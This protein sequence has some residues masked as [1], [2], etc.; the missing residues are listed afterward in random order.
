MQC[1]IAGPALV[2]DRLH[3][4]LVA[5]VL[6]RAPFARSGEQRAPDS[7][8]LARASGENGGVHVQPRAGDAPDE[9]AIGQT[10]ER[11]LQMIDEPPSQPV[12][13]A[14][15][16]G[17]TGTQIQ[18]DGEW[19]MGFEIEAGA[20][21]EPNDFF[22]LKRTPTSRFAKRAGA[23]YSYGGYRV[24]TRPLLASHGAHHLVTAPLTRR[25]TPPPN[26]LQAR[27]FANRRGS[28]V[29]PP[30]AEFSRPKGR[31]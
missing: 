23:V 19:D 14:D 27:R 31:A 6:A 22:V 28:F 20:D 4:Q 15:A 12:Y 24:L 7:L 26:A 30:S 11:D 16:F 2:A 10:P 13:V 8:L 3:M 17:D 9:N 25:A 21:C 1:H 5:L 18:T 29:L